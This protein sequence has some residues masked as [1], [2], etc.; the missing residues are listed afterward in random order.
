MAVLGI[1]YD[2][3]QDLWFIFESTNA[4]YVYTGGPGA[5]STNSVV[6]HV[7]E[8]DT[9][10]G[11]WTELGRAAVPSM[12]LSVSVPLQK[13]LAY[14][15]YAPADSGAAQEIVIVD[16]SKPSAPTAD[17]G[18]PNVSIVPLTMGGGGGAPF[19]VAAMVG[20]LPVLTSTPG[21]DLTLLQNTSA[22]GGGLFQFYVVNVAPNSTSVSGPTVVASSASAFTA[23]AAG[24]YLGGGPSNV[25][26]IPA[27]SADASATLMQYD[28]HTGG[29]IMSAADISFAATSPRFL[30]LAISECRNTA[31]V[32]Q[33]LSRDL[34]AVPLGAGGTSTSTFVNDNVSTVTIDPY[35]NTVFAGIENGTINGI[36]AYTLGGTKLAPTFVQR[37]DFTP[38]ADLYPTVMVAR[39]PRGFVCP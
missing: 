15:A 31:L 27:Q 26:G 19:G 12:A 30:P 7:R 14:V 38:P 4:T 18:D 33:V 1:S 39:S 36:A 3:V 10:S 16:T 32:G 5:A 29:K 8:L 22:G 9:H 13:R 21:G 34:F 20:A 2:S 25:I 6:L 17:A 37:T 23:A 24:A 11:L 35:S 28:P